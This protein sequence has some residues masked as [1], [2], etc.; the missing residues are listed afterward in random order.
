MFISVTNF[1]GDVILLYRC[2][3]IWSRNIYVVIVPF[4]A[5]ISGLVC[6]SVVAWFVWAGSITGNHASVSPM[7]IPVGLASF[8]LPLCVNVI[9]TTLIIARICHLDSTAW[10]GG[11]HVVRV[12]LQSGVLYALV[13]LVFV[14]LYAIQHPAQQIV[15]PMAVQIYGIASIFV[16]V[17]AGSSAA[18]PYAA[19][20]DEG[21]LTSWSE[22]VPG[23]THSS[24]VPSYGSLPRPGTSRAVVRSHTKSITRLPDLPAA[25]L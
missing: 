14:A 13:Q 18:P 17:S 6:A 16:I 24:W 7:I 2:W 4:L 10:G 8:V 11:K 9:T 3:V 19:T 22:L 25:C 12:M 1:I 5:S 15:V 20:V 21:V 23:H